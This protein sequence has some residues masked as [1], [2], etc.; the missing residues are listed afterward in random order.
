MTFD[1]APLLPLFCIVS[2]AAIG[3][4]LLAFAF[5]QRVRGTVLRSA[6]LAALVLALLNPVLLQED[7]EPLQS[8]VSIVVDRSQSQ[9]SPERADQTDEALAALT[10]RLA[11]HENFDVRV[12][13]SATGENEESPS[14]RLFETLAASLQD[15][16]PARVGGAILLTD[17]QV[18]D[19]PDSAEAL[20]FDA[21]LYGLVTGS[22]D[23]TDRR[24]EM[25]EAPRFGI[26]GED[27]EVS[28]RVLD[29]GRQ[30]G[31][32]AEVAI[33]LNGDQIAIETVEIGEER[34]FIFEI[35]RGGNNILEF[36]VGVLEGEITPANNRTVMQIEG[37]R[38]NLRVLL[39]SGEPHA[40]ERAWRNLLKS[41]AS[42]DLVHFTILR[43]PEKQDGTPIDELSLIAFPTR[44]LFVE[45][46]NEFDLIVFDRYQRRGVLPVLYYDYIAQYV[47]DGGALLIAAGPEHAGVQS[48]ATTPLAPVL[49]AVPT[50][51]VRE[52]GFY[53]R[54]SE[55]GRRH[56]V[57]RDLTGGANEPPR[58]GRWFRAVE[59]D[60]PTGDTILD[61]PDGAP[62]LVM[63][64]VGEGRVAML[65]S[66]HGWLWA[67][68]FEGGGPHVDLYRRI[69]HWLMKEPALEEEA[70]TAT[71]RGRTLI[72]ERQTMEDEAT[73]AT[74]TSPSGATEEITL[75][76]SEDGLFRTE[77]A[78]GEVGLFE[79]A[80][81]E[82]SALAHVGA[83]N[84]PE[85][86]GT[87]STTEPLAPIARE[88]GGTV[89]RAF[90]EDGALQLPAILPVRGAV[91]DAGENRMP[92]RMTDE[93]V[94]L[95]VDRYPLF[96][97]FLGFALM[98]MAL[99]ATWYREGK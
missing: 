68:G 41:D 17:G 54:L 43:P 30:Q 18:H 72:V 29:D 15:V 84:A 79:V 5:L 3:A 13:E 91:R 74:L 40:G 99:G 60:E 61:G 49:P 64:R 93:T 86:R 69:A 22:E 71:A 98:L 44:E 32:T 85:F 35:P 9:L 78:T 14:T 59:V 48:I 94:L 89:T 2:L 83:V 33:R 90:A 47:E 66:D 62:L 36:E 95:G 67:R 4:A 16:P 25:V 28:Y 57:T 8:V 77:I 63:D 11:R 34:P 23:E 31:G 12:V 37:I 52:V 38:E 81:G 97:G 10:E 51:D 56:P 21:P 20:G 70:L 19:I 1:F 26:V 55:D 92:L 80:Q 42:V 50:G 65:L 58:W 45:K 39:V 53:P 75:T 24:I 6:A 46:I 82:L 27:Q 76:E 96:A 7:R 73:T 88:T 87:V